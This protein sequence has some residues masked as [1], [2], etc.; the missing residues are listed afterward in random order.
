VA[1]G[2]QPTSAGGFIAGIPVPSRALYDALL[3]PPHDVLSFADVQCPSC[4]A[5]IAREEL[6]GH[7]GVGWVGGRCYVNELSYYVARAHPLD[8]APACT[9]CRENA[10]RFGWCGQCGIGML[11]NL[12]YRDRRLYDEAVPSFEILLASVA[13]LQECETCALAM[14]CDGTCPVHWVSY[15][16]GQA[17]HD[18]SQGPPARAGS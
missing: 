10:R 9:V 3:P 16:G 12:A 6:C 8:A 17:A 5:A 11:G 2:Q 18:S 13:K 15:H 14:T 4:R 1:Y 7:C